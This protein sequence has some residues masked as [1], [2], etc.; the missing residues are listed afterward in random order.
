MRP[1]CDTNVVSELTKRRPD[2][3]ADMVIAA[4]AA[5]HGLTLVMRN[6]RDFRSCGV[7]ILNP[8]SRPT[9]S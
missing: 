4:T 9:R 5:Q 7:P 6:E 1:L 8:F 3:Q 2:P